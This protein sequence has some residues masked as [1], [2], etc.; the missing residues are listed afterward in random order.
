MI[1]PDHRLASPFEALLV[2]LL[3]RSRRQWLLFFSI[4]TDTYSGGKKIGSVT[5]PAKRS[6]HLLDHE[7]HGL[8]ISSTRRCEPVPAGACIS[9][10]RCK[11]IL[12]RARYSRC[13]R[14]RQRVSYRGSRK[15]HGFDQNNGT[16]GLARC[17]SLY[18]GFELGQDFGPRGRGNNIE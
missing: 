12:R 16:Y 2:K 7:P 13:Q 11:N 4:E 15:W 1:W 9:C 10:A 8:C 3:A 14:T 17:A 18:G 6:R 5:Q